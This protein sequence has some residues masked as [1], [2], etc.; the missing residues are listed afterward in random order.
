MPTVCRTHIDAIDEATRYLVRAIRRTDSRSAR[1]YYRDAQS[2]L[3][4]AREAVEPKAIR[5]ALEAAR[6]AMRHARLVA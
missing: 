3:A 1:T 4:C 6:H 2:H 5:G